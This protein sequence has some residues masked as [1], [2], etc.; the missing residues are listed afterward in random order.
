[1]KCPMPIFNT[2]NDIDLIWTNGDKEIKVNFLQYPVIHKND[3]RYDVK[4]SCDS[5][6]CSFSC[7]VIDFWPYKTPYTDEFFNEIMNILKKR[8]N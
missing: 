6:D 3:C 4:I 7:N 5:K 1:M 8:K 2:Q